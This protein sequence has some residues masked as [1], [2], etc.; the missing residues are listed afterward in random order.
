MENYSY[1]DDSDKITTSLICENEPFS[2]YWAKSE[3]KILNL[4]KRYTEEYTD[5]RN[6]TWFLD[7]GCGTGRLLSEFERFFD[8][9]LAI[10]PDP[11]QI[12]KTNSLV[13]SQGIAKKVTSRISSIEKLVWDSESVDIILCSHILQHVHTNNVLLIL[14][15]FYELLRTE[16]LLFIMTC[17]SGE[18][19][20][21]YIKGYLK[22]SKA[23]EERI[24]KEEFN[25]LVIN[26]RSILPI[27]F[28]TYDTLF[29]LLESTGF[30]IIDYRS[31]HIVRKIPLFDRIIDRDKFANSFTSLKKKMGRDMFIAG[32]KISTI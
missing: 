7:A 10:D 15:K 26:Q 30:K 22:N 21:Y 2:G 4:M 27:H 28:F 13:E 19:N 9:I 12:D 1:P 23:I 16:G 32:V 14:K 3:K 25:N 11:I 17:H 29:E 8:Q 6:N 31:F 24:E 18:D 20:D 5:N